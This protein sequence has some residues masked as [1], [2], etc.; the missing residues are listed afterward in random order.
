MK[1]FKTAILENTPNVFK[2]GIFTKRIYNKLYGSVISRCFGY[3]VPYT[4]MVPFGDFMNHHD[5]DANSYEVVN[6]KQ[7]LRPDKHDQQLK[8]NTYYNNEKFMNNY[9][10]I[11]DEGETK[12]YPNDVKG[13]RFN[14]D[15]YLINQ[16]K[17]SL[18]FWI[19]QINKADEEIW[20]LSFRSGNFEEDNE[21]LSDE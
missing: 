17:R 3:G 14:R 11:F 21:S 1:D 7:H 16:E 19:E 12:A 20:Q 6:T 5:K 8:Y 13:L 15:N 4:C 9:E 18:K 2:Q 10:H